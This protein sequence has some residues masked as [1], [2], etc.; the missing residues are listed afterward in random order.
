VF[1]LPLPC[2]IQWFSGDQYLTRLRSKSR[3]GISPR[4]GLLDPWPILNLLH[5]LREPASQHL[6][7]ANTA[8]LCF[9]VPSLG[10]LSMKFSSTWDG[11]GGIKCSVRQILHCQF[12]LPWPKLHHVAVQS[13]VARSKISVLRLYSTCCDL[14]TSSR[15]IGE[16][17]SLLISLY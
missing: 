4:A 17:M 3:P 6:D 14:S 12:S 10:R 2:R 7:L 8:G 15:S 11:K 9:Q 16:V 5:S 1:V 13:P